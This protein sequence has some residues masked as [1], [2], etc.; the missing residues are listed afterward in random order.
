MKNENKHILKIIK[1]PSDFST[2]IHGDLC[3]DNVF[4]TPEHRNLRII[5][6]EWSSISNALLDG[7]YIRMNMPT[8]WCARAFPAHLIEEFELLY[9]T[10]LAKNIP[11]A[12]NNIL[13]LES[14]SAA[15]AYWMLW[16]VISI[17]E[18]FLKIAM[19]WITKLPIFIKIGRPNIR[20]AK[21]TGFKSNQRFYRNFTKK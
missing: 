17:D 11:A 18:I 9:K 21:T 5:D 14:F 12:K 20:I 8:C 7:V 19:C 15:C 10:E 6:F 3:P 16:N 1:Q 13:Y 4:D 2:L